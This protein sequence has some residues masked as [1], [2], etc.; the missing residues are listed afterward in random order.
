[1]RARNL[2]VVSVNGDKA[3][4]D[5]TAAQISALRLPAAKIRRFIWSETKTFG[6][7]LD[8]IGFW[9]D[10]G[11]VDVSGRTYYGSGSLF[12][13]SGR[14]TVLNGSIPSL[15]IVLSQISDEVALM[16]RGQDMTNARI[17]YSIGIF[18]TDTDRMI[19]GLVTRFRGRITAAK[20]L[21]P[22]AGEKGSITI[23]A[24]GLGH[25]LTMSSAYRRSDAAM[26]RRD[27]NDT[28]SRYA[29]AL[30]NINIKFG[31]P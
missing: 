11:D 15:S 2:D 8:P 16:A 22:L 9:N 6:G 14:T 19:D 10:V 1:M 31:T 24:K 30:K 20:I 21:T 26:R 4:P 28:Y 18:D 29:G 7:V 25:Q 23:T 17:E 5:F 27:P 3:M 13:V 12:D